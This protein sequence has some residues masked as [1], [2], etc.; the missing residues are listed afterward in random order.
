MKPFIIKRNQMLA[1]WRL[2]P[3][4]IVLGV[5]GGLIFVGG[6]ALLDS[7]PALFSLVVFGA[8]AL[9]YSLNIYPL[10]RPF[11]FRFEGQQWGLKYVRKFQS[12][13]VSGK[14][15]EILWMNL[16]G[17]GVLRLGLSSSGIVARILPLERQQFLAFRSQLCAEFEV[18]VSSPKMDELPF[19]QPI[20][21]GLQVQPKHSILNV[22]G[23]SYVLF[24]DNDVTKYIIMSVSKDGEFVRT[25]SHPKR[26]K[27]NLVLSATGNLESD[28]AHHRRAFQK[29]V[30]TEAQTFDL[31]SAQKLEEEMVE[32]LSPFDRQAWRFAALGLM[33]LSL[34]VLYVA[35]FRS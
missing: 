27:D 4:V 24:L 14:L 21:L 11:S 22:E 25:Q 12:V 1:V 30:R 19:W 34:F 8:L 2:V 13:T 23:V 18:E 16:S 32:L 6:N 35:V 26:L 29:V 7:L 28:I 15:G 10:L 5:S 9:A 3:P 33:L 31:S 17:K 20:D